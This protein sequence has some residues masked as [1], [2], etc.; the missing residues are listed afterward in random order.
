MSELAKIGGAESGSQSEYNNALRRKFGQVATGLIMLGGVAAGVGV[1]THENTNLDSPIVSTA[2][3]SVSPSDGLANAFN[4]AVEGGA[5]LGAGLLV[6]RG[7]GHIRR[8]F[9]SEDQA[10]HEMA[11][12]RNQSRGSVG[13]RVAQA[14][15]IVVGTGAMIGNFVDTAHEVSSSQAKVADYFA[16]ILGAERPSD[17][18]GNYVISNTPV[19]ELANNTSI[20]INRAN[21]FLAHAK[22]HNITAV[23]GT[24]E[25][26]SGQRKGEE[27]TKIQLLTGS[28]PS[29]TTQIPLADKECKEISVDVAK[30][31]GVKKGETFTMDGLT[32]TVNNV[33]EEKSGLNLL[34]VLFNNEDFARCVRNTPDQPYSLILAQGQK[35]EIQK[36]LA[37]QGLSPDTLTDRAFVVPVDKF[38]QN[39]KETGENSVNPLVLQAMTVA[40]L[41]AAA[42]LGNRARNR[43]KENT[44]INTVWGANGLDKHAL[45]KKYSEIAESE[46][47]YSSLIAIP[48]VLLADVYTNTGIPG[49]ALAP[50]VK[51]V[52]CIVGINYGIN[53][54]GTAIAIRREAS[55]MDLSKGHTL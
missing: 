53:K 2:S 54:A 47:L 24:W 21:G 27:G 42:A 8:A 3:D 28:L 14:S 37:E 35:T 29:E 19:P 31:L 23:P 55:N 34:P 13:R 33:I 41:L 16:N 52:L 26:H 1:V 51:T 39:S 44:R 10:I 17:N 38:V 50:S 20:S 9:S 11:H 43:L 5:I 40:S 22:E 48:V 18:I 45:S 6:K 15:L 49:A 36:L 12:A 4:L 25:W 7:V 46:A 30:E 32:L